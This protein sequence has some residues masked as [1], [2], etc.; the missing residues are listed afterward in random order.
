MKGKIG[1][2]LAV[3]KM[4]TDKNISIK[5]LNYEH[6]WIENLNSRKIFYEKQRF[7]TAC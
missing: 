3:K 6:L 2:V 7:S 4:I 5:Q 1:L